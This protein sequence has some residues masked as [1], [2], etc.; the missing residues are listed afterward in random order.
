MR[1][2]A[3]EFQQFMYILESMQSSAIDF[4]RME[5]LNNKFQ[6]INTYSACS[7]PLPFILNRSDVVIFIYKIQVL[8][9]IIPQEIPSWSTSTKMTVLKAPLELEHHA[10]SHFN[11][12]LMIYHGVLVEIKKLFWFFHNFTLKLG[13]F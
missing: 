7:L 3:K 9:A 8:S 11:L 2:M 4:W 12:T 6:T 5:N 13:T 10:I 1:I